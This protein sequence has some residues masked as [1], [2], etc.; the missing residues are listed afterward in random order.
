VRLSELVLKWF[1]RVEITISGAESHLREAQEALATGDALRAR[2]AAHAI[3]ER[4]PASV[5]G[6][7]LL[8]DACELAGLHAELVQTLEDLAPRFGARADVWLR[9]GYAR[10]RAGD[11]PGEARAAFVQALSL[12]TGELREQ[13]LYALIDMDLSGAQDLASAEARIDQLADG[14]ER[15]VRAI[16]MHLLR[17]DHLAAEALLGQLPED[18]THGRAA[19]ARG[20]TL[21]AGR[22]KGAFVFLLR[23]YVLDVLG[24]SEAL[25]TALAHADVET[26]SR[27]RTVVEA[28]GE[29]SLL[30]FRAAFL[31]AE[32]DQAGAQA[33]LTA[34]L[35]AGD[36]NARGPLL[37]LAT[38]TTNIETLRTS[39]GNSTH[40]SPTEQDGARV[41][42][43]FDAGPARML[44]VP[45]VLKTRFFTAF[46]ATLRA[47]AIRRW[48]PDDGVAQWPALADYLAESARALGEYNR[49]QEL[50]S[51]ALEVERPLKLAIVGEFNAGKSTFINALLGAD[52]A[53]TGI[54]PTTGTLHHLRYGRDRIA[55]IVTRESRERLVSSAILRE[56]LLEIDTAQVERVEILE[57]LPWLTEVELLDTPGFN[58]PDPAHARAARRALEEA[59]AVLWLLDA[60]QPFKDTERAVLEEIR[61]ARTP[62]QILVNKRDRLKDQEL[63]QVMTMVERAL[64]TVSIT[65]LAPPIALST[66]QALQGKLGDKDAWQA[67]NF[68]EVE[69]ILKEQFTGRAR[70]L[71]EAALRKR[72]ARWIGQVGAVATRVHEELRTAGLVRSADAARVLAHLAS[73][74]R[75]PE[76]YF[77]TSRGILSAQLRQLSQDVRAIAVGG[78]DQKGR[79]RLRR[80][81]A[82]RAETL[83]RPGFERIV[84]SVLQLQMSEPLQSNLRAALATYMH[85]AN[86]DEPL[87]PEP[88][89]RVLLGLAQAAATR[90][91]VRDESGNSVSREERTA[92]LRATELRAFADALAQ[93]PKA[94]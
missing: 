9:L 50:A 14:P 22:D 68:A 41:V 59:D 91:N 33:A 70:V 20:R 32:G 3:L 38:E 90:S 8:A 4:A 54:L 5:L 47:E 66:K 75:D 27:A 44:Q 13:A 21:D 87:D 6:L 23:A 86:L 10:L 62:I 19:L 1:G 42:E 82:A 37:Q 28:K 43:A 31:R 39:L 64:A 93:T 58:A 25:S 55:K 30:R 79:V 83:L 65:P 24:A 94:S 72:A 15:A 84:S 69:R 18:P 78:E 89:L 61:S 16:E 85:T 29:A 17:G 92:E 45:Y 2:K 74:E 53:P 7:A 56:A 35:T 34:A 49:L 36:D 48:I 76:T 40:G 52:I 60:T 46:E 26:A 80:Y 51:I 67:S 12:S 11:E 73:I 88:T 57:P 63:T 77:E 81:A 71:K